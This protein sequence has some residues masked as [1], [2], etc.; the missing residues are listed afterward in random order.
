MRLLLTR[1][2]ADAQR[3]A[4]A[5][6]ALGHEAI[7]APLLSIAVTADAEIGSGPWAAILITSANAAH[8]IATHTAV[9]QFQALPVFTVGQRSAQAMAAAGFADVSSAEGGVA[10]LA[11]LA[12]A[13][14][15][16]GASLLYIAGEDRS[17]DLAGD[18]RARGFAVQTAIIYRAAAAAMPAARRSRGLGKRHRRRA[19]FLA[20]QR[21]GLC[22]SSARH[23]HARG[24]PKA[25]PVLHFSRGGRAAV[26]RRRDRH[27]GRR[28]AVRGCI[29]RAYCRDVMCCRHL[30]PVLCPERLGRFDGLDNLALGIR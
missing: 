23:R 13:R 15:E 7:I 27:P 19:A 11:R 30:C 2:E 10:E 16:P 1:P 6:R 21:R 4:A 25:C 9:R 8:A 18:L 17:G 20:P 24:R 14:V 5:L 3:T 22:R 29:N 12:A 28:R 26:A